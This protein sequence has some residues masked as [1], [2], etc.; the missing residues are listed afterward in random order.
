MAYATDLLES[1]GRPA[2]FIL[3]FPI[4]CNLTQSWNRCKPSPFFTTCMVRVNI[5]C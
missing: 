4:T 2:Y 3:L 1:A 5:Y